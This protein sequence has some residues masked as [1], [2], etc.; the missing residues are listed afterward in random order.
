TSWVEVPLKEIEDRLQPVARDRTLLQRVLRT[1]GGHQI[2]LDT[3]IVQGL[4]EQRRVREEHVVVGH[5]V[6][7]QQRIDQ[8]VD[9]LEYRA[10]AIT[11]GIGLRRSEVTLRVVRVVQRPVGN[12]CPGDTGT[13]RT[14]G[15]GEAFEGQVP[16]VAAPHDADTLRVHPRLA[17]EKLPSA[18][19][20]DDFDIAEPVPQRIL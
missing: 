17:R 9:A 16:A 6:N 8:P 11:S 13:K 3:A 20:V 5:S 15:A 1:R 4:E 2:E 7:D 18:Q 14:R 12:R 19:L 10:V